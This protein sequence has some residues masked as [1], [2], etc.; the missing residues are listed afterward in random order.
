MAGAD[1]HARVPGKADLALLGRAQAPVQHPLHIVGAMHAQ[2]VGERRRPRLA[3][4]QAGQLAA[5]ALAQRRVLVVREAV[6]GRQLQG[7][8][9]KVVGQ[10]GGAQH[11]QASFPQRDGRTCDKFVALHK[12]CLQSGLTPL[13]YVPCCSAQKAAEQVSQPDLELPP[14]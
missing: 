11:R 7:L 8:L 14:C 9:I 3:Q 12:K 6:T 10:H 2:Q 1:R 5:Q 4:L 13:N